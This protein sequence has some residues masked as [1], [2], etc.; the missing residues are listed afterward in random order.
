MSALLSW[1]L[2]RSAGSGPP[3]GDNAAY[4]KLSVLL[5]WLVMVAI[6]L[7][8][9]SVAVHIGLNMHT[10]EHLCPAHAVHWILYHG[11]IC[12]V[13]ALLQTKSHDIALCARSMEGGAL[14]RGCPLFARKFPADT[15]HKVLKASASWDLVPRCLRLACFRDF[16]WFIDT[17]FR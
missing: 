14:G 10:C 1:L 8:G 6:K 4:L 16:L 9:L 11:R 15:A 2:G 12:L 17:F 13:I 7:T 5:C 3:S